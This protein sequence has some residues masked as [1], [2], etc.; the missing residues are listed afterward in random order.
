VRLGDLVTMGAGVVPPR[1]SGELVPRY[2]VLARQTRRAA[3]VVVRVLIDENGRPIEVQLKD[4][5]KVGLGFDEAALDAAR[6]ASYVPATKHGV[7]VKM[8][9]DLNIKFVPD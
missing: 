2:P 4:S 3:T 1:K 5:K 6:R 9:L 7:R 8:W